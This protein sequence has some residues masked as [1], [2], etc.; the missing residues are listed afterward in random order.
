MTKTTAAERPLFLTPETERPLRKARAHKSKLPAGYVDAIVGGERVILALK[1]ATT[2][3]AIEIQIRK[4]LTC[5]GIR[6]M[7]HDVQLCWSCRKKPR[8]TTGLGAHAADLICIVP[9]YGRFL[10]IEVKRPSN[11]NAKRDTPQRLWAKWTRFYGGI[12]GVATSVEE[13]F[14]LVNEARR[15][16]KFG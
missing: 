1:P 11:R 3:K 16:A 9:P 8:K 15:T 2:E 5:A 10:A 6:V 4:A 13:A 7:K 14:V 12:A